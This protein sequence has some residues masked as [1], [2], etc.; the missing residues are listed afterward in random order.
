MQS[1]LLISAKLLEFKF[2]PTNNKSQN[3][4]LFSQNLNTHSKENFN[5]ET[6]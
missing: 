3:H 2:F 1:G 6:R 4:F 5:S